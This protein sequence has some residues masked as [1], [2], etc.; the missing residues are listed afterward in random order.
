[1]KKSILPALFVMFIF[2]LCSGSSSVDA[3]FAAKILETTSNDQSAMAITVYNSG[4]GLVRDVR[5]I[6]F[7]GGMVELKFMDVASGMDPTS[8]HFA[9]LTNP[10]GISIWEQNYEF[11]LVS[12]SKLLEKYIG[13][14]IGFK[15]FNQETK[16]YDIK[17]GILLS[18]SESMPPPPEYGAEF[19]MMKDVFGSQGSYIIKI[20]NEIQMKNLTEIIL[21]SLPEGLITRPT[22]VWLLDTAGEPKHKV[23]MSYLTSGLNWNANYVTVVND[24]D[25]AL[26]L[27]GWVTINNT[28]GATY[29]NASLKLVAGDIHRV[30]PKREMEYETLGMADGR[31][32]KAAAAPGFEEKSFFEY[33]LY[34]LQRPATLKNNQQKQIALL[35]ST[36]VPAKKLFIFEPEGDYWYGGDT[37]KGKIQVKMQFRNSK[38][39]N[40]GIPLPKGTVRVYKADTDGSLQLIGEDTID[41]TPK[42]EDL[43][44]FLGEAFDLVGER[45]LKN[46]R[47][48][49][50]RI[51]EYDV[52]IILRNHK[53]EAVQITV[54]DHAWGDW[55]IISST[56]DSNKKDASTFEFPVNVP[57]DG[58]VKVKYTVRREY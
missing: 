58:E 18:A 30:Q 6:V 5:D 33:H 3:A 42:D 28:S 4:S 21:P 22:L 46:R 15:E 31:M 14:E 9:S 54:V 35:E 25:N 40:L 51:W 36:D 16:S 37:Q 8:V 41:H 48:I 32:A 50:D 13:K 56:H 17:R 23:E 11:D 55:T 49:S 19:S 20:G 2:A 34:T 29:N 52:E 10:G 27:N 45:I 53:A 39:N 26:D 7:P 43:R 38:E 57:K 1:M 24:K 47:K 12:K 44:L